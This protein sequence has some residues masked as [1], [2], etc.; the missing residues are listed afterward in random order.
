MVAGMTFQLFCQSI[1]FMALL[2]YRNLDPAVP[3]TYKVCMCTYIVRDL[4]FVCLFVA[5]QF[6]RVSK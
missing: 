2:A 4:L 3:T 6:A 1:M 5:C